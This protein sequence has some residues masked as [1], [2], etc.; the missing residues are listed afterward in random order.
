MGQEIQRSSIASAVRSRTI[1]KITKHLPKFGIVRV[2]LTPN[3]SLS[4]HTRVSTS[5]GDS[6]LL[7]L[8]GWQRSSQLTWL[9]PLRSTKD[10]AAS[11]LVKRPVKMAAPGLF[12]D[13]RLGARGTSSRGSLNVSDAGLT[14]KR[15]GVRYAVSGLKRESSG[16]LSL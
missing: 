12:E 8:S 10:L 11:L 1:T 2:S 6:T 5:F 14:W 13:V 3:I 15:E 7:I 9:E 16:S 4:C